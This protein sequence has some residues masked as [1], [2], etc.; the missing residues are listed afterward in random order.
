MSSDSNGYHFHPTRIFADNSLI[1]AQLSLLT[2][3]LRE[4]R[5]SV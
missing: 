4:K 3:S 1:F 5:I 2:T